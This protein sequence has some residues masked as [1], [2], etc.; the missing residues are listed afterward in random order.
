[1]VNSQV[2]AALAVLVKCLVVKSFRQHIRMHLRCRD[3]TDSDESLVVQLAHLIAAPFDM[4][5]VTS[6][7]LALH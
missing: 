2:H 4:L 5:R 1:M 3:Q 7:R 6:H